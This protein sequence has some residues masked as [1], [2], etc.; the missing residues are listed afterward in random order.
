MDTRSLTYMTAIGP[1]VF[2]ELDVKTT[3]ASGR[4]LFDLLTNGLPAP[5]VA[6]AASFRARA[7]AALDDVAP[8]DPD[9]A[10]GLWW[11][12]WRSA[13]VAVRRTGAFGKPDIGTATGLFLGDGG[14]PKQRV[15]SLDVAHDGVVGDRQANRI[16]HGRPWQALCI[17]STEAVDHFRAHGHPVAPGL[18]GENVSVTGLA[19]E[20]VRPGAQLRI[21]DVLAEVSCYAIPCKKNAAWFLDG[22]FDA[23]HHRHGPQSRV[24]ATV[25][26]PG[27][28]ETG[29]PVLLEPDA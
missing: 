25:L 16:H 26:E 10:L 11:G 27:T 29:A 20:R 24:Y 21:G 14:V 15:E 8:S 13:M 22:R 4:T 17:W 19:W 7:N 1:Y 5:A 12:E 9:A 6:E 23:M 3:L 2:S 18:A 28:V